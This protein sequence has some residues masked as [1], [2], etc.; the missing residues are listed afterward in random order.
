MIYVVHVLHTC[1]E[2]NG[3]QMGK[4]L[5]RRGPKFGRPAILGIRLLQGIKSSQLRGMAPWSAAYFLDY[6]RNQASRRNGQIPRPLP[7]RPERSPAQAPLGTVLES[8]PS[9]RLEP[10]TKTNLGRG[11]PAISCGC[12]S[13]ERLAY[14]CPAEKVRGYQEDK[15]AQRNIAVSQSTQYLRG[16]RGWRRPGP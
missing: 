16:R 3:Q 11:D 12:E 7:G 9:S 10:L 1:R 6:V 4:H 15:C 2:T 8:F 13:L 14:L 5:R